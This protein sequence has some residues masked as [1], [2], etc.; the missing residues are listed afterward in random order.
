MSRAQ[1]EAAFA[2]FDYDRSGTISKSE[3]YA[4]LRR[5]VSFL[6][7]STSMSEN[8]VQQVLQEFDHD[9]NGVLSLGEFIN[10][11]STLDEHEADVVGEQVMDA[12]DARGGVHAFGG[13]AAALN[14]ISAEV[15]PIEHGIDVAVN[16]IGDAV[17]SAVTVAAAGVVIAGAAAV[18][19]E[20]V[21]LG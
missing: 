15:R 3:L 8:D 2:V 13:H 1:L 4:I 21:V 9:G 10:A 12:V 18:I 14:E 6:G 17:D 19:H 16:R 20:E 11:I 5:D 7:A